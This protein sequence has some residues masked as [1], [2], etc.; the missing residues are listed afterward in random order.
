M[1]GGVGRSTRPTLRQ[2][3]LLKKASLF[4]DVIEEAKAMLQGKG[5]TDK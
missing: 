1:I 4:D 2:E 5:R 3:A